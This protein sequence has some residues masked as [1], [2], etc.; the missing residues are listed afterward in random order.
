MKQFTFFIKHTGYNPETG[1][2]QYTEAEYT[3]FA[4][5]K[6]SAMKKLK[7][8]LGYTDWKIVPSL[9]YGDTTTKVFIK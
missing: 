3:V 7:K 9:A 2:P 5:S 8:S 4:R 6:E 1:K